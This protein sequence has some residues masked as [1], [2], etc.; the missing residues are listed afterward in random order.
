MLYVGHKKRDLYALRVQAERA[1]I[2][3][4]QLSLG[5]HPNFVRGIIGVTHI[6]ARFEPVFLPGT[7]VCDGLKGTAA[8]NAT[9]SP[10]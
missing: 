3:C 6:E 4:H 8:I 5:R 10:K 2:V 1:Y 9:K 7:R